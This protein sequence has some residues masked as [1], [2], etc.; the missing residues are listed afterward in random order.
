MVECS[1]KREELEKLLLEN[2]LEV[3]TID[4]VPDYQKEFYKEG[5]LWVSLPSFDYGFDI[6]AEY[7]QIKI[8][9]E[10]KF[11]VVSDDGLIFDGWAFDN[12][13]E[14][15]LIDKYIERWG[16][17]LCEETKTISKKVDKEYLQFTVF[18]MAQIQTLILSL[19]ARDL[20]N[21]SIYRGR[22][23]K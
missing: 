19:L 9:K 7:V 18:H 2:F 22:G 20:F 17:N 3:Q 5:E 23:Q 14:K 13:E 11:F 15:K 12:E 16:F 1:M 21:I 6:H 10:G 4:T 8:V